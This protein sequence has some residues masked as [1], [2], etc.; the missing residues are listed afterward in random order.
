MSD[1]RFLELDELYIFTSLSWLQQ[2]FQ[3]LI[4]SCTFTVLLLNR[5]LIVTSVLL[6]SLPRMKL[7]VSISL[8]GLPPSLVFLHMIIF[9]WCGC[10][11]FFVYPYLLQWNSYFRTDLPL[12]LKTPKNV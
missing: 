10:L 1:D 12:V 2:Y 8:F 9:T 4:G 11:N 6:V 7:V 3:T 5:L